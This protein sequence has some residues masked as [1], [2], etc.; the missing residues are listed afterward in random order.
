MKIISKDDCFSIRINLFLAFMC[1]M[2]H[3]T[4][5]N[6]EDSK[7]VIGGKNISLVLHLKKSC[8]FTVT[9]FEE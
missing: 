4:I 9:S 8:F 3:V 6:Y 2:L 5:F 7:A 1:M